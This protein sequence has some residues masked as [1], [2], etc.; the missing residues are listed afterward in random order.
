L[1]QTSCNSPKFRIRAFL[2]LRHPL[3]AHGRGAARIC[4]L[5]NRDTNPS[6]SR[7]EPSLPVMAGLV[8]AIHVLL[9]ARKAWMAS[10]IG[11]PDF[12]TI[13]RDRKSETSDLRAT[14]TAMTGESNVQPSPA[15]RGH[16][17]SHSLEFA[18][19]HLRTLYL[20]GVMNANRRRA[21]RAR[22]VPLRIAPSV[23]AVCNQS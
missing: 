15:V 23:T 8:P 18:F 13:K 21:R 22:A 4:E 16:N 2:F 3:R 20:R 10:E 5:R 6:S 1:Y 14:S 7:I 19:S 11:V 12:R 17:G 9:A